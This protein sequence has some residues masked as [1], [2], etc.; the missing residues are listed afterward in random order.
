MKKLEPAVNVIEG[1]EHWRG[2]EVIIRERFDA[3]PHPPIPKEDARGRTNS[4]QDQLY[5]ARQ[6]SK[7]YQLSKDNSHI[8]DTLIYLLENTPGLPDMYEDIYRSATNITQ[9][10]WDKMSVNDRWAAFHSQYKPKTER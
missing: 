5:Y 6:H 2:R 10:D 8:V 9:T 7:E 4:V 3:L 1:L